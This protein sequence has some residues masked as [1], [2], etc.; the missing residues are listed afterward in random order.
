MEWPDVVIILAALFGAWRGWRR[1]LIAELTGTIALT[2]G[3]A[4]AFWYPGMWDGAVADH[5]HLGP[6]S[7]H[8][9]AMLGYAA[10]A[11]GIVFALGSILAGIA[12]LPLVGTANAAFGTLVG[13]VQAGVFLWAVLYVAL[14]F[15]LSRDLRADL[16]RSKLVAALEVANPRLDG[17]LRSSLPWFV[18]PFAS[19][20]FARHRV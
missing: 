20:I 14:F 1:G 17:T 10:L 9:I 12:K 18:R 19:G 3:V 4:A 11:Y 5:T 6:G 16:H 8:V 2:A 15:P 7:S 13:V